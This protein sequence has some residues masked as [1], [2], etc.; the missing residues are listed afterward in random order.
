MSQERGGSA[1]RQ[2]GEGMLAEV[3]GEVTVGVEDLGNLETWYTW[4][5]GAKLRVH[6]TQSHFL[7]AENATLI[8]VVAT[9]IEPLSH[10]QNSI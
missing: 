9:F 3:G 10:F 5:E 2:G 6:Q 4:G 1:K 8:V 7:N